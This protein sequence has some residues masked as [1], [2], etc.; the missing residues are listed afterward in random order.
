M[1]F[2]NISSLPFA[3][4]RPRSPTA[5]QVKAMQVRVS[6]STPPRSPFAPPCPSPH[7]TQIVMTRQELGPRLVLKDEAAW[8][9]PLGSPRRALLMEGPIEKK[10]ERATIAYPTPTLGRWHCHPSCAHSCPSIDTYV[11]CG[12]D[13]HAPQTRG[14]ACVGMVWQARRR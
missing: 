6:E 12:F 7:Y 9:A 5:E 14:G 3:H 10:G 11:R 1:R 4:P 2:E 13:G 8:F